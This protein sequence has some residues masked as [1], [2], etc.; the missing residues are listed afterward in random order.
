MRALIKAGVA[1]KAKTKASESPDKIKG[2]VI[3]EEKFGT[4]NAD[5]L[6][7]LPW[8]GACNCVR[9]DNKGRDVGRETAVLSTSNSENNPDREFYTCMRGKQG[10][11]FFQWAEQLPSSGEQSSAMASL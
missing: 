11:G 5:T 3:R 8:D 1:K 6:C 10:C 9:K 7:A 4:G 2:L